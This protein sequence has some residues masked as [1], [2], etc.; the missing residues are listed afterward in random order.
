MDRTG[1]KPITLV[2]HSGVQFLTYTFDIDATRQPARTFIERPLPQEAGPDGVPVQLLPAY[3]EIDPDLEPR[4]K[5]QSGDDEYDISTGKALEMFLDSWVPM[6]FFAVRPGKTEDGLPLFDK[7]PSNWVR[8]KLMRLE[9]TETGK[10][11]ALVLAFDTQLVESADATSYEG[12]RRED[13]LN[14]REFLMAMR[15]DDLGWFFSDERASAV[16]E[17]P[18]D[19]QEWL[20]TWLRELFINLRQRQRPGRAFREADLE[21]RFEHVARYI[22][23]LIL[24]ERLVDVGPVKL[25]DTV[26]EE[27]FAKPV[28]VDLILDIGNSRSCGI[29]IESYAGSDHV[30]LG[31]S[32]VLQ[33]RDLSLPHL[34]YSEP[35]ESHVELAQADFGPERLSRRSGR[36]KAFLWP[37]LVRIGQEAARFRELAEGTEKSSGMS[38]PKR[39]LW[40]TAPVAQP[41]SFQPQDYDAPDI[42]PLIQRAVAR[43]MNPRGDVL[44]EVEGQRDRGLYRS[45]VQK[46]EIDDLKM[47]LSQAT[48]SRSSFFTLMTAEI[49]VQALSMINNYQVRQSRAFTDIPRKLNRI[50]LTLPTAMPVREQRIMRSRVHAALGL[51]WELMSWKTERSSIL[52]KPELI[53][54]W[55]EASCVQF[56]YIYT[57]IVRKFGGDVVGFLDL[58]G[59]RRPYAEAGEQ[60]ADPTPRPALRLASI[61][62]GGGTTDLMITTYYEEGRVAIIP[63]QTFR[64]SFRIAGDDVLKAVIEQVVIPCFERHLTACGVAAPGQF[65]N[66][67][68]GG[69][70]ANMSEQDKHL[71]QQF[72]LRVL[73]P[74]GIDLLH[75]FEAADIGAQEQVESLT[76]GT[77][78]ERGSIRGA[79]PRIEAY[80]VDEANKAATSP[81]AI[82]DVAIDYDFRRLRD[83]VNSVL[84]EIFTNIAEVLEHFDCD[85]VLLAGRPS[86]LPA[87]VDLMVNKLAVA[88]DRIIP[89][90]E[91][92]VGAWYPFKTRDNVRISDPKTATVVGG[93]LCA[94][95]ERQIINLT[96]YTDRLSMRSTAR[97]LGIMETSGKILPENV[98]FASSG[99][100]VKE[101][102]TEVAYRAPM[103]IG[104]RQLPHKRWT[105]TPLYKLSLGP[106]RSAVKLPISV[107][108]Q[109]SAPDEDVDFE[110]IDKF[111]E[112]EA[113][114]EE[115][116][117]IEAQDREGRS[118][119]RLM[120]LRLDTMA[121]EDGYWLDTG[122]LTIN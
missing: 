46:S 56:V 28:S 20:I 43:Y 15:F 99:H 7:G 16:G 30:D 68:F 107:T 112:G 87:T 41:W 60:P 78:I 26:S 117:I 55:D 35:F 61:D 2:P 1:R 106:G 5:L 47:M 31:N 50:I 44:E 57:E 59:R 92:R 42:P 21:H 88:P 84:D 40:D 70:R 111:H 109:R 12:L 114:K 18:N 66:N 54:R 77:L 97:H 62:I 19:Y 65:L 96:I 74:L 81:F 108:L 73:R 119:A 98:L 4:F 100:S 17:P 53:V 36:L 58:A 34:T 76:I 32:M 63:I 72:V 23:F 116:K 94:L 10:T 118:V 104:Y 95:A 69:N 90:H 29:L 91:Y 39:Y 38:S 115:I 79:S 11:H 120:Q 89:M 102:E 9:K 52:E 86:R 27:P 51:V 110:E 82:R 13:A 67:R 113:R 25:I 122:I 33:L 48:F 37:S 71:R 64:E 101:A 93:M 6:P 80:L 3:N 49:I 105:A 22:A 83:A 121:A 24:V 85:V 103:R 14:E 8:A 75:A 45:L